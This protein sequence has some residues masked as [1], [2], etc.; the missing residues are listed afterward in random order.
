MR[1]M[2]RSITVLS[3]GAVAAFAAAACSSSPTGKTGNLGNGGFQYKCV[4]AQDDQACKD[5]SS[6]AADP[7][8]SSFPTLIA[9]GS[10]FRMVFTPLDDDVKSVGNPSLRAVSSEY[11]VGTTA[12]QFEAKKAGA[13][14]VVAVSSVDGRVID[15]T[16]V[17]MADVAQ[18]AVTSGGI[19]VTANLDVTVAGRKDVTAAPLGPRSEKLAGTLDYV[20][21]SDDT[22]K[23]AFD[24]PDPR[25]PHVSI[26]GVAAGTANVTVTVRDTDSLTPATTKFQV[27]VK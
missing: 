5:V 20:W 12:D 7:G 10:A 14:A 3:L 23:V 13:C 27:T 8:P 19:P 6:T 1:A 24:V 22:S 11:L 4:D 17:H 21:Q 15:Y 18:I 2:R 9:T 16:I 26:V 25:S